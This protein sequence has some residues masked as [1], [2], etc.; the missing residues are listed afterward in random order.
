[1][2]YLKYLSRCPTVPQLLIALRIYASFFMLWHFIDTVYLL[3][4]V[5]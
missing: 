5:F 1:M 2:S 3:F 4:Q